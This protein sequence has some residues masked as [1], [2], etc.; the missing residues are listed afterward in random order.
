MQPLWRGFLGS[1]LCFCISLSGQET[2]STL[3][4]TA[5]DATGAVVAGV[6]VTVEEV[7]TGIVV[8]KI[9]TDNQGN[10]EIPGL[11]EGTYR[12]SRPGARIQN[13]CCE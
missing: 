13:L 3:R 11:K 9:V 2:L 4:G 5:T 8:R 10:Y 6:A 1:C 7:S 12:L